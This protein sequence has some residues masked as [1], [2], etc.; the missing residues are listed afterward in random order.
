MKLV[1]AATLVAEIGE[2]GRLDNPGKHTSDVEFVPITCRSS[3][4]T[5]ETW[6]DWTW[7]RRA[8]QERP[9]LPG[10]DGRIM[11]KRAKL[12]SS[13]RSRGRS[14]CSAHGRERDDGLHIGGRFDLGT[15][16]RI[17]GVDQRQ[18]LLDPQ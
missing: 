13:E 18:C 1:I 16:V 8:C 5:K 6:D 9:W 15:A 3:S 11:N 10:A 7:P 4:P 17:V 14:V 12:C 2:I